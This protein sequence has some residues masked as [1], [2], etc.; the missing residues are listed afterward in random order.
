MSYKTAAN[1]PLTDATN[2]TV[3]N[4]HSPFAEATLVKVINEFEDDLLTARLNGRGTGFT[5]GYTSNISQTTQSVMPSYSGWSGFTPLP[6]PVLGTGASTI[7]MASSSTQDSAT[8]TGTYLYIVFFLDL[9][10]TP[11]T[12]LVALNGT[13]PVNLLS[14]N[15]YHFMY[16]FPILSGS[17]FIPTTGQV[18]SN[19]GTIFLGIG[20]SFSTST[21]FNTA[22]YMWNRPN[23]GFM[24]SGVYVVPRNKRGT[25]WTVKFNSDTGVACTF[26][27]YS[28]SSRTSAWS[29]NAE[30]NVVTGLVIRRTLA[31]GFLPAGAEFTVVG[32]KTAATA[33]IAANFVMTCYEF[34]ERC[35]SQGNADF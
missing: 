16:G 8:G 3:S 9:T 6:D 27:T 25:L 13:T 20:G 28:R 32:N 33:N 22:N 2:S 10:L 23:D 35:F 14:T 21:G 7:R 24:S 5:G 12:E 34:S 26:K 18:T 19:V 17:G 29:L 11:R 31:G 1:R 4:T 15:V 30:D